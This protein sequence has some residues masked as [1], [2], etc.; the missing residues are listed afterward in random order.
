[1]WS[2]SRAIAGEATT[3]RAAKP[4]AAKPNAGA[5]AHFTPKVAPVWFACFIRADIISF[6]LH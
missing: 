2:W 1:M 5:E 4:N 3:R 6:M